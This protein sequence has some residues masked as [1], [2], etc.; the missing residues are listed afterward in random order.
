VLCCFTPLVVYPCGDFNAPTVDWSLSLPSASS[1]V[2]NVLCDIVNDHCLTQLILNLTGGENIVDLLLTSEPEL[3]SHVSVGANLSG[4]HHD[5]IYFHLLTSLPPQLPRERTLYNHRAID[6]AYLQEVFSYIPW[7]IIDFDTSIEEYWSQWKDLFLSAVAQTVPSVKWSKKK[8]KH[9]FSPST[10]KLIHKKKRLY[11]TY[12]EAP[13]PHKWDRYRAL[14][15]LVRKLCREDTANHSAS[16]QSS[17]YSN[18][19]KFWRW[20]NST[21]SFKPPIPSLLSSS[22]AVTNDSEKAGIFNQYF[23]SVFTNENCS[24][25]EKLKSHVLSDIIID[26]IDLS[27]SDVYDKLK[28]L[29]VSKACGPDGITPYLLKIT[30]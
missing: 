16:V 20:I 30:A 12:K 7:D 28:A 5:A 22:K 17:Y 10:I 2:V 19:K 11:T 21:K 14:S 29:D 18:P 3:I 9:W 25:T 13:S 8:L 24:N 6:S 4:C 15:N 27:P 26:S 23:C 1:A